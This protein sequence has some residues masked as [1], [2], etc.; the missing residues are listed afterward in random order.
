MAGR[1]QDGSGE[2]RRQLEGGESGWREPQ[3][4]ENAPGD[5]EGIAKE[6]LQRMDEGGWKEGQEDK[7]ERESSEEGMAEGVKEA[8]KRDQREKPLL[9]PRGS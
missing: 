3:G 4:G 7:K 9:M 5:L 8:A 6:G 1:G 2:M